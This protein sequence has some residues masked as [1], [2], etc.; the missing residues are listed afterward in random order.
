MV[1]DRVDCVGG[2]GCDILKRRR[3][4]T[5]NV[6]PFQFSREF[7]FPAPRLYSYIVVPPVA[8]HTIV[9][10]LLSFGPFFAI[11]AICFAIVAICF[12]IVAICFAIVTIFMVMFQ[13]YLFEEKFWQ[14]LILRF[15][16]RLRIILFPLKG[17]PKK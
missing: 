4:V 11:V 5:V 13:K 12:A 16:Q 17:P 14:G 9:A 15:Q 3:L 6:C 2:V 8:F 10:Q 1:H 7:S